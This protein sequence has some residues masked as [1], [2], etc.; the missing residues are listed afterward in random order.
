VPAR[1]QGPVLAAV[2][3][4]LYLAGSAVTTAHLAPPYQNKEDRRFFDNLRAGLAED[5]DQVLLDRLA[6]PDILLPL[7]GKDALLSSIAEPLP[8]HPAFDEPSRALRVVTDQGRLEEPAVVPASASRP[9]PDGAC[10]HAV[11]ATPVAIPLTLPMT[12]HNMVRLELFSNRPA[13]EQVEIGRW[14]GTVHVV[15]GPQVVW[16]VVPGDA[17]DYSSVRI[18]G[19]PAATLCVVSVVVGPAEAPR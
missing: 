7:L 18:T 19:S 1:L 2:V 9:G 16:L 8:E 12:G 5:R 13:D 10:G 6:P 4:A 11:R 15:R 3:T 17:G 14:T